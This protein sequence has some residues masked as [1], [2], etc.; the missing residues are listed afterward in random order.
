MWLC[1]LNFLASTTTPPLPRPLASA[2]VALLSL[3]RFA[4]RPAFKPSADIIWIVTLRW[5]MPQVPATSINIS[6]RHVR[7]VRHLASR[8][9]RNQTTAGDILLC[10]ESFR[11]PFVRSFISF[12]PASRSL[13]RLCYLAIGHR[14]SPCGS[15]AGIHTFSLFLSI[16]APF[17]SRVAYLFCS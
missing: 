4:T 17:D 14:P 7:R 1:R 13:V 6:S 5:P 2:S 9:V 10:I 16:S 11:T 12:A 3:P 8:L 15:V